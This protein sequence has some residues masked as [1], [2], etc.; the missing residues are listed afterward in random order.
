MFYEDYRV[1]R[2]D[3]LSNLAAAYGYKATDAAKIWDD[4][5]NLG[6]KNARKDSRNIQPPDLLWVPIPWTVVSQNLT[7]EVDGAS[8][9]VKRDGELGSQ[10]S[11]V[12]TV[13]Q[14]NQ[15]VAGTTVSCVDGCPADDDLPFYWTDAEIAAKPNRRKEFSDRSRRPPPATDTTNWRAVVSLAVVTE[16]R[17]TVWNSVVW[18]WDRTPAGDVSTVGPRSASLIEKAVHLVNLIGGVGIGPVFFTRAGWT[19][20]LA[21]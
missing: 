20:R 15:P 14:S 8:I 5:K 17:V 21:P 7:A 16:K 19:F 11:W 6:V 18:G 13:Y 10:L 1:K 12:Q 4:P 2:G 9:V 3:T